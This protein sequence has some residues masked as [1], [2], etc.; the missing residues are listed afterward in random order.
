MRGGK[1]QRWTLGPDKGGRWNPYNVPV[2]L[3]SLQ[4]LETLSTRSTPPYA[5]G[6]NY[7]LETACLS[8]SSQEQIR[9]LIVSILLAESIIVSIHFAKKNYKS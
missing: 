2:C 7:K 5:E 4:D 1:E 9:Q 3:Q 6:D 8:H